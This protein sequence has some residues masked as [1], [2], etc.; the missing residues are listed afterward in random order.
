MHLYVHLSL[1]VQ[2]NHSCITTVFHVTLFT[3]MKAK[4]MIVCLCLV[5]Q[6][7]GR[8]RVVG[9]TRNGGSMWLFLLAIGLWHEYETERG[10]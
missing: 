1:G 10:N 7:N 8:S 2:W 9:I 3:P 5:I 6:D 4:V